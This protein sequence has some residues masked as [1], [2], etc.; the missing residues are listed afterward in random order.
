MEIDS[1]QMYIPM[2]T[3]ILPGHCVQ[4]NVCEL[5]VTVLTHTTGDPAVQVLLL[6]AVDRAKSGTQ[7]RRP[8]STVPLGLLLPTSASKASLR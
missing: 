3:A 1:S 5:T 2:V 6:C 4:N 8:G 7:K